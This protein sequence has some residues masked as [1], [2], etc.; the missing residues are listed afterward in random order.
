MKLEGREYRRASEVVAD[1]RMIWDNCKLYNHE[2]S[3]FGQLATQLSRKFEEKL[4]KVMERKDREGG[5]SGT[6]HRGP[7]LDEKIRFTYNLYR[8]SKEEV[9]YHI[10]RFEM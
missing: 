10:Y 5:G 8:I 1:I 2:K 7:T 4:A 6:E 3:E 9:G